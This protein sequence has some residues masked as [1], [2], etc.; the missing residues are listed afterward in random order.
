V[1]DPVL[2]VSGLAVA[3]SAQVLREAEAVVVEY[4]RNYIATTTTYGTY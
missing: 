3:R 2:I 1:K 4:F